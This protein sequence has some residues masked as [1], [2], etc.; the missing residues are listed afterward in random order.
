MNWCHL[1][2]EGK[3]Y[4]LTLTNIKNDKD[5]GTVSVW[6]KYHPTSIWITIIRKRWSQD[7]VILFLPREALFLRRLS[8]CLS[9]ALGIKWVY[10]SMYRKG[11]QM[12]N[13][14]IL[15]GPDVRYSQPDEFI[16]SL[17][18]A[19]NIYYRVPTAY[20]I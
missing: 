2:K 1:L 9:Q 6:D 3:K 4:I 19:L 13:A 12:C 18:A 11:Y 16:N 15:L 10:F 20:N 5:L 17:C 7:K 8:L 14:Q